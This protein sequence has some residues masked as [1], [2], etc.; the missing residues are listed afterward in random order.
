MINARFLADSIDLN[1]GFKV[2]E[3]MYKDEIDACIASLKKGYSK[4]KYED[5]DYVCTSLIYLPWEHSI[6][7][8]INTQI[9]YEITLLSYLFDEVDHS[10]NHSW[11]MREVRLLWILRMIAK[12]ETLK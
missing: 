2:F 6:Q 9:D 11:F 12:L 5:S 3:A 10:F 8:W 4:I 1:K 7:A